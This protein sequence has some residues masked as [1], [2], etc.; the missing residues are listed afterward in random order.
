MI[1]LFLKERLAWI[2]FFICLQLW[3][4]ILFFLDDGFSDVSIRYINLIN[5]LLFLIFFSWRYVKELKQLRTFC[6]GAAI[7]D[8]VSPFQQQMLQHVNK[9][10]HELEQQ[11]NKQKLDALER[12]DEILAW[13]HEMKSPMTALKLMTDQIEQG[14]LKERIE[15]EWL[16]IYLLLD[17]QLHA[18]RLSTIEK[19]NRLEKVVLQSVIYKEI[20][21]LRSWCLEKGIGIEIG[22]LEEVVTT[23]AKWLAF[24]FRQIFSNAVKY[25]K[26]NTEIHIYT[27]QDTQGHVCLYVQDAG[28]G[29]AAEDLPRV[30][31]K[32]YTGTIGR[33]TMAATGMGLYLA[34]QSAEKLGIQ[35]RMT[36]Q[37]NVGTTVTIQFPMDNEYHKSY[38]M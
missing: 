4:N 30:F 17:Q 5:V 18:T 14:T 12:H 25:S 27:E 19:D 31:Q 29:I 20:R 7:E 32:S 16:R 23:D 34:K 33:E 28:C 9:T 6:S 3:M 11:M 26:P 10:I 8:E 38:G 1:W 13:V 21:E 36:S 37:V 35:L 22:E 15:Y 2:A 24:I